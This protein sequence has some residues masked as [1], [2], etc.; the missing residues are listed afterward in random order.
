MNLESKI[1]VITRNQ[2]QYFID[3]IFFKCGFGTS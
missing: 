3:D 2:I 1:L